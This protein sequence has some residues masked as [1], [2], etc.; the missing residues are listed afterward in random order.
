VLSVSR[1]DPGTA[2]A[3]RRTPNLARRHRSIHDHGPPPWPVDTCPLPRHLS[4]LGRR[5]PFAIQAQGDSAREP[6]L[7]AAR[8]A[9]HGGEQAGASARRRYPKHGPLARET[10]PMLRAHATVPGFHNS[11][12]AARH[13]LTDGVPRGCLGSPRAARRGREGPQRR[14]EEPGGRACARDRN[15][16]AHGGGVDSAVLMGAA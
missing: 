9:W 6:G 10:I 7:S 2:T 5:I 4:E 14:R 1:R 12:G 15:G 3:S 11:L 16:R 13:F 8:A